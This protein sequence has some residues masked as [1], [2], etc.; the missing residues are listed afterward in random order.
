LKNWEYFTLDALPFFIAGF[1]SAFVFAMI[2]IRFFLKLI[3][4]VKLVPF[5]IYRIVLALV[6]FIVYF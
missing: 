1:I 5:A 4:K 3:N 6:I 2:S